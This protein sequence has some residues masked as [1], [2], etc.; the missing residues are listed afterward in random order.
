MSHQRK[1][2]SWGKGLPKSCTATSQVTAIA[3]AISN[4]FIGSLKK[5]RCFKS[6]SQTPHSPVYVS[7]GKKSGII[8]VVLE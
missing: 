1:L 3:L 7:R 8:R 5:P 6:L 2:F 4:H